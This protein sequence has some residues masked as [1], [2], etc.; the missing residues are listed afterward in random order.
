MLQPALGLLPSET[1][2]D[3]A[4][5][6]LN[7]VNNVIYLESFLTSSL[8]DTEIVHTTQKKTY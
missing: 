8:R 1:T 3:I 4:G 2:I 7:S 6:N 5:T